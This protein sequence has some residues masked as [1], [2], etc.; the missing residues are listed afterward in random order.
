MARRPAHIPLNVF[1]NA[2]LVGVL[3]RESTGAIDFQYAREWL[4]WRGS[5]PISL[6]LPLREDRH[7]GTPV[8]NVFDNLLPDN[9]A[10][11]RR[12]AERVGADGTDAYSMLAVLGHDCVGALQFLPD[13]M[14]PGPPGSVEGKP[15]SN[16]DVAGII[17][18][19]A[20]APLG[21]GED[22]DFRISIAGAQEKTAL[23]RKD[24]G[25]F[26]PIGTAATTHILKPQIGRLP[27]G[28][29]LS[30]S[31]EN[32]YLCLKLLQA[33]GVP[34]AQ[35]QIADFGERRTLIVERFDRL[36]AR[37]GRLLRLPQEDICQALSVPP[38]RKYQS[39]GGPGMR[40]IIDLLKGSDTPDEDIATFLRTCILFWLIG[41]TEGHAK[42]FSIF[43]SPGGRFRMTPL[44]D[45]LTAQPSLD[46]RQIPRKK[47]KLAMSVGK[48]RH[49]SI[50]D[51]MP[52]HF[53]QTADIA[54]VGSPVMR[55]IFDDI[56]ENV[57]KQADEVIMSLPRGFPEQLVDAVKSAIG[58]RAALLA[59]SKADAVD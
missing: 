7:I 28:I 8:T 6:S 14:D 42:N 2:R 55:R 33:F 31:V 1:L 51:I 48:N 43:L 20:A 27:N 47:F 9:D 44:Y 29:D 54:G 23:L 38:T 13:G 10:M 12:V 59:D 40:E 49:Y 19:L 56:A 35:A 24:G 21:L 41:A 34:A 45:V 32:E 22:E 4:D 50:P 5:F 46:T 53:L 58:K 11:R 39:D 17:A 26:K 37:D 36:W 16:E 57:E 15:V 3:R 52:G 30:N 18:N 25:W